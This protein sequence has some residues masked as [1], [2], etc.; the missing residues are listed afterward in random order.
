MLTWT[1]EKVRKSMHAHGVS[2][3]EIQREGSAWKQVTPS[4]FARRI[5]A[6]T[7]IGLA[8]VSRGT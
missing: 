3:I 2:V 1:A 6:L 5:T 7:P 8:F 4:K